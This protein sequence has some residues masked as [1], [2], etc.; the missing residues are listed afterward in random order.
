M[1]A[2]MIAIGPWET[3]TVSVAGIRLDFRKSM[4]PFKG[5]FCHDISEFESSLPSQAVGSPRF[6]IGVIRK[7]PR[8]GRAPRL[9]FSLRVPVG[10]R[11]ASFRRSVSNGYL[12]VSRFPHLASSAGGGPFRRP[13]LGG[14]AP[15]ARAALGIRPHIHFERLRSF[16]ACLAFR[17]PKT[18]LI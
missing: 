8:V 3:R 13:P 16:R 12:L 18:H 9:G 17:G 4:R 6:F 14:T 10:Q 5:I 15:S 1:I 7:T 11:Q 2:G